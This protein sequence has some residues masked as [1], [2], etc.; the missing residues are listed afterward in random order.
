[1]N[2]KELSK[3][4]QKA[5]ELKGKEDDVYNKKI[6]E[7]TDKIGKDKVEKKIQEIEN[8]YGDQLN[9]YIKKINK[10]NKN[11]TNKEKAQMIMEMKKKLNSQDQKKVDKVINLFKQYMNNV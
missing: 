5:N 10:F 11:A 3:M 4:F 9:A 6:E 8:K 1:M 7:L 2:D